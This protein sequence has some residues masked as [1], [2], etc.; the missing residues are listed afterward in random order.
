VGGRRTA[1]PAGDRPGRQ[2]GQGLPALPDRLCHPLRVAQLLRLLR[3]GSEPGVRLQAGDPEARAAAHLLRRPGLGLHRALAGA[4]L[5]RA[6]H[7][8]APHR[9]PGL[10]SEGRDRKMAPDVARG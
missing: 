9:C 7:P 3:G 5:R 1:R 6:R 8:L 2:G 10:R 4:H